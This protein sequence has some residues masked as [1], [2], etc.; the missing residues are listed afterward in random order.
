MSG[1]SDQVEERD[2]D[3]SLTPKD[4]EQDGSAGSPAVQP[5]VKLVAEEEAHSAAKD[6]QKITSTSKRD[7]LIGTEIGQRYEILSLI[8]RGARRNLSNENPNGRDARNT[9]VHEP[10][11]VSGS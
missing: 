6:G 4:G 5:S 9:A 11:A 10:G 1:G 7:P 2:V 8:G 3:P